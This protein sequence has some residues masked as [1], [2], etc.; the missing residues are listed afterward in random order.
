[1]KKFVLSF[2]VSLIISTTSFAEQLCK[3]FTFNRAQNDIQ[4]IIDSG[5]KVVFMV[6]DGAS[7]WPSIIVVFEKVD[8]K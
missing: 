3:S 4:R 6:C 2:L 5:Y 1:M 7:N 8:E